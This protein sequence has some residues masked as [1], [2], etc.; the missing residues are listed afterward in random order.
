[1]TRLVL[2]SFRY[3]S[4]LCESH[5]TSRL[6]LYKT[7]SPKPNPQ[8]TTTPIHP[9]VQSGIIS[10]TMAEPTYTRIPLSD[11]QKEFK[12]TSTEVSS[13]ALG[14]RIVGFSDEFFAEAENLIKVE[15]RPFSFPSSISSLPYPISRLVRL[16]SSSRTDDIF[17]SGSLTCV[18]CAAIQEP[19]R[20]IRPERSAVRWVGDEAA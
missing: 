9:S 5:L 1:V 19:R 3:A 10:Q 4:R 2:P 13:V 7:Q 8:S 14:G 11:F 16:P 20:T 12:D 18:V 17:K 6:P 15:V